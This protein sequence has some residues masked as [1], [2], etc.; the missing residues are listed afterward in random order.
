MIGW[1]GQS[2][3]FNYGLKYL[4]QAPQ[5]L[6]ADLP[7]LLH[8]GC[9]EQRPRY[10][11]PPEQGMISIY[12]VWDNIAVDIYIYIY[13]YIHLHIAVHLCC[14]QTQTQDGAAYKPHRDSVIAQD[15]GLFGFVSAMTRAFKEGGTNKA[16]ADMATLNSQV[17]HRG[18]TAIRY[19]NPTD[20]CPQ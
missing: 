5:L 20:C 2:K 17:A 16:M 15:L 13:I 11:L 12:Q 1:L 6:L 18:Y 3:A 4:P 14:E 10:V 9:I 19:L 8:D 7:G